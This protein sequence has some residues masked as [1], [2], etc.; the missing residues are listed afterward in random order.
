[1]PDNE[2]AQKALELVCGLD[3]V[4][5]DPAAAYPVSFA[6][7]S[8]TAALLSRSDAEGIK[9]LKEAREHVEQALKALGFPPS[10]PEAST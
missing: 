3:T 9:H 10:D 2:N 8:L 4:H 5:L 6:R 1:M 7:E